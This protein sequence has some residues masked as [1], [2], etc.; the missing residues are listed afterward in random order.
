M[1]RT[2]P[3]FREIIEKKKKKW[4]KFREALR[5]REK[6]AFDEMIEHCRNHT[7]ASSQVKDPDPFRSML[8]SIL[9]EHQKDLD[10]IKR[11]IDEILADLEDE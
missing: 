5:K 7:S 1:G 6:K 11:E 8:L 9:L 2:V 4:K 10:S 3:T